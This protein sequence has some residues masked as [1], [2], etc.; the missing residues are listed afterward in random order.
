M[1][2]LEN[3]PFLAQLND[4][5]QKSKS[6][7]TVFLSFKKYNGKP[8][9][10]KK[11]KEDAKDKKKETNTGD[12]CLIRA[13]SG[14]SKISTILKAK[15]LARFQLNISNVLKNNMDTLKKK[16]KSVPRKKIHQT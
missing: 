7:G 8:V 10:K 6:K 9:S 4:L 5:C 14:D 3:E 1:V 2:L 13:V 12:Q 11:E 16:E 15:D